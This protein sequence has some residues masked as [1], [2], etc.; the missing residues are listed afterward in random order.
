MM[1]SIELVVEKRVASNKGAARRIRRSGKIP[2]VL[3]GEG[4]PKAL[5]VDAKE[6]STHFQHLSGNTIINL[7]IDKAAHDV[8][9]KETQGDILSGMTK[10]IDFYAIHAG[11]KLTTMVP[12]HLDGQS[13]GVHQG[14]ILEHKIEQ[15]EVVC[16]PKD[17][18]EFFTVDISNLN[19]GDSVHISDMKIPE[20]VEV[21]ADAGLTIAVITHTKAIVE[22]V[23]SD[24][25][26]EE[27]VAEETL[28]AEEE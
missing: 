23:E 24:E 2:A 16:L 4:E 1:N 9:I 7:K 22:E 26:D 17:M 5:S 8:L 12:V 21:R 3:Y 25:I 20:N 6:W 18:P 13:I 11:Q 14:G 10:H 27:G 28:D 15:V 19:I